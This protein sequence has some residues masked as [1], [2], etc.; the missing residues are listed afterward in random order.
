MITLTEGMTT[1]MAM[2]PLVL[3]PPLL[4]L[5]SWLLD[6]GL[7]DVGWAGIVENDFRGEVDLEESV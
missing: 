1:P 2:V 7:A 3:R 6:E 5:L 4:P